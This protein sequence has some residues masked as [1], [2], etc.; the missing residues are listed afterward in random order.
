[1]CH[2]CMKI[3][4]TERWLPVYEALASNVRLRIINLLAQK[5]MNIKELAEKLNLSNAIMTMHIRKLEKAGIIKAEITPC[6][7]GIQKLCSLAIDSLEISFPTGQKP[8]RKYHEISIPVGH[9]TDFKVTPTCGL[10]SHEKVIGHFDDP[11][12]FLDPERVNARILWFT[13]GYV[14]YKIPNYLLPNQQ[15]EE[16]EISMELGSEAPGV[17]DNWPSDISFF[18]NGV[19]IGNWTSPGDFGGKRGIYTPSWWSNNINQYGLL[20]VIRV[21]DKGSFI[22]G[23][24]LSEVTIEDLSLTLKQ[25][26]FRIAVLDDAKHIGGVTLYGKGFGNYDQDIVVRVYYS[27]RPVSAPQTSSS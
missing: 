5:P 4:A 1:M 2:T 23:E 10:A 13:Q 7:G 24:K 9:Y 19:Y 12:Y 8:E 14:E 26:S 6:R 25:W 21:N 17:N 3:D 15:P 16:L 18:I 27:I 22:D 11:R 20:K